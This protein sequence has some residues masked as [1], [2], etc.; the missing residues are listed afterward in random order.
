MVRIEEPLPRARAGVGAAQDQGMLQQSRH[1]PVRDFPDDVRVESEIMVRD[2]IAQPSRPATV[3]L[4]QQGLCLG[5]Q[6][7]DG[8]ADHLE[9]EQHRVEGG[10]VG[11]ELL[12]RAPDRQAADSL[13][14]GDQVIQVQKSAT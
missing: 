13:G 11:D 6:L 1:M 10:L 3:G 8:F 14:T 12:D 7:L 5:R 2:Q 9:V 4:R